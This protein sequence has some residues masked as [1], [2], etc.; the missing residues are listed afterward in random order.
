VALGLEALGWADVIEGRGEEAVHR[1]EESL[2]I[3]QRLGG[4]RS[5][6]RALLA[7]CQ[8]LVSLGKVDTAE[9]KLQHAL[10]IALSQQEPRDINLAYHLLA[11]SAL[12]RGD[13]LLAERLY[14]HNLRWAIA[15]GDEVRAYLEVEGMAMSVA[16]QSRSVKAL[17][18]AGAA[19]AHSEALGSHI[20]AV[21]WEEL[22]R[23]YLGKAREEL[24]AEVA[25]MSRER[26]EQTEF[27]EAVAYALDVER[28]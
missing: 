21:F 13:M 3:Q 20:S 5:A 17:R 12:M 10:S 8:A 15:H 28:D 7:V 23:R 14:A 2:R 6:N 25:A 4:P 27:R 9:P 19:T 16:G 18:L 26:G 11:D 1:F 22:K 24:G